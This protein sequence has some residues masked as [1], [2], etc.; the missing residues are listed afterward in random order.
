MAFKADFLILLRGV[1][2]SILKTMTQHDT[3]SLDLKRLNEVITVPS[4]F[5]IIRQDK[6]TCRG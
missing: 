4:I 6:I 1:R 3:Q 5:R 2:I